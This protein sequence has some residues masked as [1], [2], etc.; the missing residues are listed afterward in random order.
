MELTSNNVKAVFADCLYQKDENT[1]DAIMVEGIKAVFGFHPDRIKS[2]KKN[3]T[4]MLNGL[5]N[6]FKSSIGG[7]W[8]FLNA[9]EREDGVQWTSLH[10]IVEQLVCLGI[11]IGKVTYCLPRELWASLQ[12][13]VPYFIVQD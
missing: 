5:P 2:H 8:S 9:C 1:D 7:G 6:N 11:A 3:I 12:G 4:S 10:M 13:G